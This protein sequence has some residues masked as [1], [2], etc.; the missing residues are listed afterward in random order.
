[1]IEHFLRGASW[2]NFLVPCNDCAMLQ[3]TRVAS[4]VSHT[5]HSPIWRATVLYLCRIVSLGTSESLLRFLPSCPPSSLHHVQRRRS[6]PCGL[7]TVASIVSRLV[8]VAPRICLPVAFL[9]P[10]GHFLYHRSP[11][12]PLSTTLIPLDFALSF[13][14]SSSFASIQLPRSRRLFNSYSRLSLVA[15]RVCCSPSSPAIN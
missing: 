1:M 6:S 15:R 2:P 10:S 7:T 14:S 4:L 3:V 13:P 9:A 8:L 5:Y 11:S 12:L